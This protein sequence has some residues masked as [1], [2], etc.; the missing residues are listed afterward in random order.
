[1]A[2]TALI[3]FGGKSLTGVVVVVGSATAY[4]GGFAERSLTRYGEAV[5]LSSPSSFPFS[6]HRAT[7][8]PPQKDDESSR[9]VGDLDHAPISNHVGVDWVLTGQENEKFCVVMKGVENILRSRV[10]I[11]VRIP[12]RR[13][14][15]LG[16]LGFVR[17]ARRC[18]TGFLVAP[19]VFGTKKR[20]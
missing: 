19:I 12:P 5:A 4:D 18:R 16:K 15:D 13:R 9:A 11:R 1:M 2:R 3:C 6:P 20:P 7:L 8:P 17:F 10:G 14:G